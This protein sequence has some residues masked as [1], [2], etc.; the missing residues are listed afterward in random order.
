MLR[1]EENNTESSDTFIRSETTDCH[2]NMSNPAPLEEKVSPQKSSRSASG[3][4]WSCR[5][6]SGGG[7]IAA[8]IYVFSQVHRR[9]LGKPPTVSTVFQMMFATGEI[10][11]ASFMLIKFIST[12]LASFLQYCQSILIVYKMSYT[13]IIKLIIIYSK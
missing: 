9:S 8:G 1:R 5:L 3:D 13:C 12:L 4:C 6:L 11:H 10:I 2:L 7:L